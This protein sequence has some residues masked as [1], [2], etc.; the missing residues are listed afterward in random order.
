[1]IPLAAP[2]HHR[3]C[4]VHSTVRGYE[5]W[6]R[7]HVRAGRIPQRFK[8]AMWRLEACQAHGQPARLAAIRWRMRYLRAQ[9]WDLTHPW[10][11]A[12]ASWYEDQGATASG[13]HA[14]DGVANLTLPFGTRV[15]FRYAGRSVVA[16]VDDRGP[17]VGGRTWDLSQTTAA[18]LGFD[19]VATVRYRV[20]P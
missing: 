7:R 17:Y 16:V 9:A 13:W 1:M 12:L 11:T 14:T 18:A 20:L 4:Q 3:P 19:G 6:V 10:Q 5:A 8:P 15:Q 2:V